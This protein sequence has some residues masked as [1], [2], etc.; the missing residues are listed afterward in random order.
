MTIPLI[1][2]Q[3]VGLVLVEGGVP[4]PLGLEVKE[5]ATPLG[6]M[7]IGNTS[8]RCK[9]VCVL[10]LYPRYDPALGG[11]EVFRFN[12]RSATLR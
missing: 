9:N 7:N 10:V 2:E 4:L 5:L 3:R 1:K 11:Y 12:T 6:L 8:E